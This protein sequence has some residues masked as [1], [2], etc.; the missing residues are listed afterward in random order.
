MNIS[1]LL[2]LLA[3]SLLALSFAYS[4]SPHQRWWR[5]PF[6]PFPARATA[7]LAAIVALRAWLEVLD[8]TSATLAWLTTLILPMS[9]LFMER[10]DDHVAFHR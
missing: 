7:I 10:A 2:T 3:S 6:A 5:H 1:T 8:S 4:A 9:A